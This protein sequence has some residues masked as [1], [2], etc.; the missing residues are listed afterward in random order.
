[1]EKTIHMIKFVD[2]DA[3]LQ[4]DVENLHRECCC[5]R[6]NLQADTTYVFYDSNVIV[7]YTEI[8]EPGVESMA[9]NFFNKKYFNLRIALKNHFSECL[10]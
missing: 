10:C 1:M 4:K 3:N 9:T 6:I 2:L 8:G 5:E 7:G